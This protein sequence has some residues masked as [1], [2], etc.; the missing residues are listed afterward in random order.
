MPRPRSLR[1][2]LISP[3]AAVRET[4]AG[5]SRN[6]GGAVALVLDL[7]VALTAFTSAQL[8]SVEQ[9]AP[10]VVFV[11]FGNTPELA[12][13]LI[14]D[15]ARPREHQLI[16]VGV[17]TQISSDLLLQAVRAGMAE[18][19]IKPVTSDVLSDAVDR[20]RPRLALEE[21]EDREL[22]RTM[23]F[24]SPKGG[25]G[26]STIVA[27]LAVELAKVTPKK[28]LVVDLDAE[29]GEISLIFGI[30]PQ[31]NL[32][33][34]VQ[35]FHRMDSE[36]LGSYIEK[37]SSGVHVLS[38]PFHPDRASGMTSDAVRQVLFYLRGL[39]DYVLLDT[40]KSFSPETLAAFEQCDDVFLIATVDLPSLR[41][42]QRGLPMLRRVMPRGLDQVR[43]LINRYDP[44][45]EISLKDVERTLELKVYATVAN[46]YEPVMRSINSGKPLVISAPKSP[47]ARDLHTLA[48]RIAEVAKAETGEPGPGLLTRMFRVTKPEPTKGGSKRG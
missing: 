20:L 28:V 9:A 23:A 14:K 27:N 21:D 17:G 33:D 44:K 38:A 40:S 4:I 11:D 34:L 43:L 48:V 1:T 26:S 13:S 41:N 45:L 7:D 46:D 19:L 6:H 37:H 22:G 29:L 36:L 31:F 5:L 35:N 25:S 12:I 47:A 16:P 8:K 30:Q 18:Y 2:V 3:D 10:A 39:Y 15:L 32:I 24:F 42:I